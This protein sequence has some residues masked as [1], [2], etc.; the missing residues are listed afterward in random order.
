MSVMSGQNLRRNSRRHVSS[1]LSLIASAIL[2]ATSY[3]SSKSLF[4]ATTKE[5]SNG[6]VT[7]SNGECST[8]EATIRSAPVAFAAAITSSTSSAAV[9]D[10]PKA[11]TDGATDKAKGLQKK[12]IALIEKYCEDVFQ[13]VDHDK[14]GTID[15]AELH[16]AVLL[17]FAKLNKVLGELAIDPPSTAVVKSLLKKKKELTKEEFK[18]VFL[19]RFLRPVLAKASSRVLTH[20]VIVPGIAVGLDAYLAHL[21]LAERIEEKVSHID[22][23]PQRGIKGR[24]L[25]KLRETIQHKLIPPLCAIVGHVVNTNIANILAKLFKVEHRLETSLRGAKLHS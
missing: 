4:P 14:S 8:G 17:V 22:I 12:F 11:V 16:I 13:E 2:I 7:L 5:R 23:G 9:V 3:H 6:A 1:S 21:Q 10:A 18:E 25:K 20:K 19:K 24:I 15:S